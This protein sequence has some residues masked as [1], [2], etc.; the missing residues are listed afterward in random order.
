MTVIFGQ[1]TRLRNGVLLPDRRLPRFHAGH[2]MVKF[3]YGAIRQ[4]PEYYVT[5]LLDTSIS[6]TMVEGPDLLVF[7]H[8]REHQSFH[9]GRTRR[10]LYVPEPVLRK[11]FEL[12]YDYWALT[13]TLV[14][15]S[16]PLMD[17]LL[18]LD[19]VRRCQDHYKSRYTLGYTFVRETLRGLNKHLRDDER[20][21]D[22]EFRI[23]CRYYLDALYGLE[24]GIVDED[25]FDVADGI[26]DE[27]RERFW[28]SG[29]L[30][31]LTE[32]YKY[33]TYFQ[34]DRDIVHGAAF[35]IA[36]KLAMPL[37]PA[38]TDDVM[39]DLW[40]EARFKLSRSIK[41]EELLEQL[42]SMGAEGICA[43]LA[44]VA[45]E[46]VYG[47]EYVTAN[48]YDGYNIYAGLKTRLQ[49][50]SSSARADV[51]GCL[52]FSY[53][54][55]YQYHL[56]EKRREF[57]EQFRNQ[58]PRSR[59]ENTHLLKE[60]LMRVV[61]VRLHPSRAPDFRRRIEFASSARLL[62]QTGDELL[63]PG[64][65][66]TRT[67]HLCGMLALLDRH[68]L[69]HTELLNQYRQL[70][71][72]PDVILKVDIRAEIERLAA[73]LPASPYELTSDPQGYR[74]RQLKYAELLRREPDSQQ[75]FGLLAAL[76]IRLDR[77]EPYDRLVELARGTGELL[78]P[79][80]DYIAAN[81]EIF[82]TEER[83]RIR[84]TARTL[85]SELDAATP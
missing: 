18:I 51:P 76:F 67:E 7:H 30:H 34:I 84:A 32:T 46:R 72:Q 2:G 64:D 39:H 49:G 23:F 1:Q 42:I 83:A 79:E 78:R 81:D 12:G 69:Y 66:D 55:L 40:D 27:P 60:I 73:H 28:A 57:L 5:A 8:S 56:Y 47:Y 31:D 3:F 61:E 20:A 58:S 21:D 35:E 17:Y 65:P 50:Y 52:G 71:G 37:E 16:W 10:T 53:E 59:E 9:A 80:L 70:S 62:I 14:Q 33:P 48:R 36:R 68:P 4:L 19:F 43:F 75:L 22:D 6:V 82:G 15:E 29:K 85:L 13:E 44:T 63:T 24:R 26:F 11:A 38:S 74:V 41:T 77:A 54:Q 25:P 45:E